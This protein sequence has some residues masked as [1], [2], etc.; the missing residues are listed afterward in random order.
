MSPE[1]NGCGNSDLEAASEGG[2]EGD[3]SGSTTVPL[4]QGRHVW[5]HPGR[6]GDTKTSYEVDIIIRGTAIH[7][8]ASC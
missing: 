4:R 1:T 2:A 3:A 7:L 5:K 8:S 6:K